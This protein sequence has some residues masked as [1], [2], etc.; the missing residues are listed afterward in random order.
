M[1]ER[2]IA[3]IILDFKTALEQFKSGEMDIDQLSSAFETLK[4]PNNGISKLPSPS[5]VDTER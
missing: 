2:R 4:R 3:Y 5:G 1:P